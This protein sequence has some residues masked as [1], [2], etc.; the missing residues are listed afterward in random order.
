MSIISDMEPDPRAELSEVRRQIESMLGGSWPWDNFDQTGRS[1][2]GRLLA[3]EQL[4]MLQV[5]AGKNSDRW[6]TAVPNE[7]TA[8]DGR[9]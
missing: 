7:G 2:Y 1:L 8:D 4:L 5:R 6:S 3:R 9:T